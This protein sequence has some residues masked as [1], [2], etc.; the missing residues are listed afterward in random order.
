LLLEIIYKQKINLLRSFLADF[1]LLNLQPIIGVEIEFYLESKILKVDNS[2]VHNFISKLKLELLEK[3][4]EILDIEP[5]QGNGQ[6]EI[7]T[8]PYS[9]LELLCQDII[10]IKLIT[11]NLSLSLGYGA[12]F[13]SQPY[14]ND[15]G[16]SLQINFSLI[17]LK[18][19]FLFQ[20]NEELESSYLLRSIAGILNFVKSTMI[21]FA[22]TQQDYL[23]FNLELNKNLFRNKKYTAPVNISWGY[24]NRT[25]LI[26]I[27]KTKEISQRRI[28]FRLAASDADIYLV[29]AS[30]LLMVL[31]AINKDIKPILPIYGNAFDDKYKLEILPQIYQDAQNHFFTDSNIVSIIKNK[32]CFVSN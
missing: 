19:N 30:F 18:N 1:Q 23:R 7:K 16:S 4:I 14:Q 21:F 27:P 3:N 12:N 32:L 2:A 8:K 6:I 22:P 31:E 29:I 28:E 24:N 17:D 9:D 26:R 20:K 10:K 25:A 15:C 13:L 5:E 11:H